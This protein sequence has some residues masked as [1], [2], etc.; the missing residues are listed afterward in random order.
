MTITPQQYH[1]HPA[2]RLMPAMT[3]EEFQ[4]L[5]AD[6]Q[7]HGLREPILFFNEQVVD[8][9][10]RLRA[11]HELGIR[12][13]IRELACQEQDLPSL[14]RSLN[15]HRRHLTREQKQEIIRQQLKEAPEKSDRWIARELGVSNQTVSVA[16]NKLVAEGQLCELHSSVGSDGKARKRPVAGVDPELLQTLG[17]TEKM[18]SV[19]AL[20]KKHGIPEKFH[21]SLIE[22]AR[23]WAPDGEAA[24]REGTSVSF[25][26]GVWWHYASGKAAQIQREA[27]AAE[28]RRRHRGRN[29][30]EFS[31]ELDIKLVKVTQAVS[32]VAPFA[33]LIGN[34]H[35]KSAL[36]KRIAALEGSLGKLKEG[37]LRPPVVEK[38]IVAESPALEHL[39]R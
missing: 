15:F 6:I 37:L 28:F 1:D 32:A 24:D 26:G 38:E 18:A 5:K 31:S 30:D 25:K 12:P 27:K 9:R 3:E 11:C 13:L 33:H 19:L 20:V 29:L 7:Q 16:R 2:A 39:Q 34:G 21:E 8:G 17:S 22:R 36:I 14:V 10:H 35:L 4:A 23:G